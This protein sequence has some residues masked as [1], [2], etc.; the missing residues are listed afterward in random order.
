[1]RQQVDQLQSDL[2]LVRAHN[3]DLRQRVSGTKTEQS[4]SDNG[5]AVAVPGQPQATSRLRGQHRGR[6][7]HG[8]TRLPALP[9]VVEEVSGDIDCPQSGAAAALAW[10]SEDAQV[11]EIEVK[12]DRRVVPRKRYRLTPAPVAACPAW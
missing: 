2:K 12:A 7:G 1:M 11:L 5:L 3:R 8:R 9:S 4:H 6:R 10:G